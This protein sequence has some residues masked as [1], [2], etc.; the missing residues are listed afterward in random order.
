M[1]L[2]VRTPGSSLHA[3]HGTRIHPAAGFSVG[4]N[5]IKLLNKEDLQKEYE[6]CARSGVKKGQQGG[7]PVWDWEWRA[8]RVS[9]IVFIY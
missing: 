3:A 4:E 1:T 2:P 6:P 8:L 9:P 5:C 7:G